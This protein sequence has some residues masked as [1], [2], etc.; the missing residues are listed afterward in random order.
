MNT[1]QDLGWRAVSMSRGIALHWIPSQ[2]VPDRPE[3]MQWY[4]NEIQP[5]LK[6]INHLYP[7]TVKKNSSFIM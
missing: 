7:H 3:V 6:S 2:Q 5:L 1:A 4:Q